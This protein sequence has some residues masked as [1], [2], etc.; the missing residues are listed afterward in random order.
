MKIYLAG[1]IEKS[2]D[3]GRK[4]RQELKE[5]LSPHFPDATFVDPCDFTINRQFRSMQEIIE[6]VA[7]WKSLI[8]DIIHNDID[9]VLGCNAVI[10][11]LDKNIGHGT[12]IESVVAFYA[13]IPVIGYLIDDTKEEELYPWLRASCSVITN[14]IFEL[15]EALN[16]VKTETFI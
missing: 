9:T 16:R 7:D 14:N 2:P 11:L 4:V 15:I 6:N 5:L 3:G 1:A 8:R 13:G 12:T 10:T